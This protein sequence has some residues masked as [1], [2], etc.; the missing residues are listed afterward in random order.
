MAPHP[1]YGIAT[2]DP[3]IILLAV[4]HPFVFRVRFSFLVCVLNVV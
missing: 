3:Q 1:A 4:A 2:K